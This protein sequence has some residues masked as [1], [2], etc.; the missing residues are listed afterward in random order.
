MPGIFKYFGCVKN[1]HLVIL[2][3]QGITRHLNMKATKLSPFNHSAFAASDLGDLEFKQMLLSLFMQITP[4]RI[5]KMTQALQEND[6]ITIRQEAH[7]IRSEAG[8]VFAEEI[9]ATATQIE[10]LAKEDKVEDYQPLIHQLPIF[11]AS[12]GQILQSH[13]L[14]Q[15]P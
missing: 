4:Q 12:L 9:Q 5:R 14:H 10:A 15:G 7:D 8:A 11:M 3:N 6:A 2:V 1:I 13:Q